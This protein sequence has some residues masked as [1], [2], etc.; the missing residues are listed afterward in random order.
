[1]KKSLCASVA[2]MLIALP[3][4]AQTSTPGSSS[5][6]TVTPTDP[7]VGSDSTSTTIETEK[8]KM[9]EKTTTS[10]APVSGSGLGTGS[11]TAEDAQMKED[12]STIHSGPTEAEM[13]EEKKMG[14]K[15]ST[16]TKP[17]DDLEEE[18]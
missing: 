2:A 14:T 12:N 9:E 11:D 15:T 4:Y 8:Q 6:A 7:N 13:Q 17:S 18:E 1:M 3:L 10:P 16:Q 5:P